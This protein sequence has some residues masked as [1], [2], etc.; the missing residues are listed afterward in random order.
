M[1]KIDNNIIKKWEPVVENMGY[2]LNNKVLIE[3]ICNYCEWKSSLKLDSDEFSNLLLKIRENINNSKRV[4]IVRTVF[5]VL[6]G[7]KEYELDNGKYVPA[8][9]TSYYELSNDELIKVFGIEYIKF[10]DPKEFRNKQI[11]KIIL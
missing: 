2:T 11:D 1:P 10:Y 9:S 5:N 6:T 7:V 3:H 4:G 8:N